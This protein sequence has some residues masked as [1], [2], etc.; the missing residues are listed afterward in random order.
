LD[1]EFP[2]VNFLGAV[3]MPPEIDSEDGHQR[4]FARSK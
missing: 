4:L 1:H 3:A 2:L